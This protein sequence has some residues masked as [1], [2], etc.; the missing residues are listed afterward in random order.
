MNKQRF[1]GETLGPGVAVDGVCEVAAHLDWVIGVSYLLHAFK[2]S[3]P[4]V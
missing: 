4:V 2:M 3:M 1:E